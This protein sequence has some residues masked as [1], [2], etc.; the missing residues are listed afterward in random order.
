MRI[1]KIPIAVGKLCTAN[2]ITITPNKKFPPY[3]KNFHT[4]VGIIATTS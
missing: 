3:D 2:G 4:S 1:L